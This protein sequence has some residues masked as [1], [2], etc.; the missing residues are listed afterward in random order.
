MSAVERQQLRQQKS[1]PILDKFHEWLLETQD[2][3]LPKSQLGGAVNYT[4]NKWQKLL[5]YLETI[6]QRWLKRHL[7]VVCLNDFGFMCCANSSRYS[8]AFVRAFASDRSG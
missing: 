6:I 4:I 2:K 1:K 8:T 3:V 5:T 7:L